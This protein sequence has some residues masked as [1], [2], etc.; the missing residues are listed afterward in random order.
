[1]IRSKWI[2]SIFRP[3]LYQV[4][5][6]HPPKE[7]LTSAFSQRNTYFSTSQ[8]Q[9][10]FSTARMWTLMLATAALASL[11]CCEPIPDAKANQEFDRLLASAAVG[12]LTPNANVKNYAPYTR[13]TLLDRY[14]ENPGE[15]VK[16]LAYFVVINSLHLIRSILQTNSYKLNI[17]QILFSH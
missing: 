8:V 14:L 15:L 10:N 5:R 17:F 3:K 16:F 13:K 4:S 2:I 9:T 11:A 1:M 7:T 12:N 6:Q